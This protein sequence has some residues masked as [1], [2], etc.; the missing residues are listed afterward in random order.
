MVVRRQHCELI[1]ILIVRRLPHQP[2]STRPRFS[3]ESAVSPSVWSSLN[4]FFFHSDSNGKIFLVCVQQH[5]F[6]FIMAARRS[7]VRGASNVGARYI[8]VYFGSDYYFQVQTFFLFTVL[9]QISTLLQLRVREACIFLYNIPLYFSKTY[10][11]EKKGFVTRP[12][13]VRCW[14][15]A[16]ITNCIMFSTTSDVV[17]LPENPNWVV[18]RPAQQTGSMLRPTG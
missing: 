5:A 3:S 12:Y 8:W 1:C 6:S 18:Y 16:H 9:S 4:W 11:E 15:C 2:S 17:V 10:R 13:L 7:G 14:F